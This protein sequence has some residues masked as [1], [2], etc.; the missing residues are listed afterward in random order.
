MLTIQEL[1]NSV[2][3]TLKKAVNQNIVDTINGFFGDKDY[4]NA[5]MSNLHTYH[6]VLMSGKYKMEDY[7]YAVQYVSFKMQ[8]KTNFDAYCLTFPS[9]YKKHLSNGIPANQ[10]AAYVSMY[11]K[12][13]L[14]VNILQQAVIPIYISHTHILYEAIQT[15]YDIMTDTK[16]S[17][18]VRSDAASSLMTH[19]AP[20][21]ES[22]LQV[23]I[24]VSSNGVLEN[25]KDAMNNLV[26]MQYEAI[27]NKQASALT[28]AESKL[29]SNVVEG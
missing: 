15:Q 16:V 12:N 20:P 9:R 10:I 6:N 22:K 7:F 18:K 17:P 26:N 23:D 2:P 11:N 27:Q 21:K 13:A 29:I 19:L 25:L 28:I 24:G 3:D 8:G 5:Y 1:R 14:V 4:F